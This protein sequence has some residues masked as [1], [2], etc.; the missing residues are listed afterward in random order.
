MRIGRER[1]E[2]V[3][4]EGVVSTAAAGTSPPSL[5]QL[6]CPVSISLTTSA[7][8]CL[9]VRLRERV[10]VDFF[11][12]HSAE[13]NPMPARS[14]RL[15]IVLMAVAAV[16][17]VVVEVMVVVVQPQYS[18]G[19]SYTLLFASTLAFR[20]PKQKKKGLVELSGSGVTALLVH[21][22]RNEFT[23]TKFWMAYIRSWCWSCCCWCWF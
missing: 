2:L 8:V 13:V 23:K 4:S 17:V 5:S 21:V 3:E 6:T 20:K 7:I 1:K 15:R 16:V 19:G 14:P 9:Q 22:H 12:A 11:Q 18:L 10:L